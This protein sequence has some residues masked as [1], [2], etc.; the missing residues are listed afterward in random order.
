MPSKWCVSE[1]TRDEVSGTGDWLPLPG[2]WGG[3]AGRLG[4]QVPPGYWPQRAARGAA[5]GVD[6]LA[7]SSVGHPS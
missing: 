1:S 3:V 7:C 6:D 5:P 4:V 2:S